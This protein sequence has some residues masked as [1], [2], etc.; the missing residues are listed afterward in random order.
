M[1]ESK[2]EDERPSRTAFKSEPKSKNTENEEPIITVIDCFRI[3]FGLL[4]LSSL[5]SYFITDGESYLWNYNPYWIRPKALV[6]KLVRLPPT[7]HLPHK[8]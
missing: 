3:L 1:A 6:A 7:L 8:S 4:L 5:L 2:V